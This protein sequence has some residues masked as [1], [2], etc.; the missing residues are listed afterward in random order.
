MMSRGEAP[1]GLTIMEKLVG[2]FLMLIGIIFFYVTYTNI[3][4][5]GSY[6]IIFLVAG[7]I[8]IGLGIV[9]ITAKTE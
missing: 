5:I 6:P 2:L 1:I 3:S 7:L 9:M 8:L 4:S